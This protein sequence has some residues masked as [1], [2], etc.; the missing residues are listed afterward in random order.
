MIKEAIQRIVDLT[1][2]TMKGEVVID[3]H[4]YTDRDL[5]RIDPP[6]IDRPK[7]IK[8]NSLDSLILML[9]AE[10]SKDGIETP[11]FVRVNGAKSVEVYTTYNNDFTRNYLY[12]V[13][14]DTPD[15]RFGWQDYEEAMIA[16]RSQFKQDDGILYILD[17]LKRVTD[18]ESVSTSDNGLTQTVEVKKGVSLKA[19]ENVR[20]H[21]KLRPYRTFLEIEQP[22]SEFLLRLNENGQVG[23]FEADG[24]M[25]KLE[26]R[27]TVRDYLTQ[28]LGGMNSAGKVIVTI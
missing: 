10:V 4:T 1:H 27:R 16:L 12:E 21:V 9:S 20:P 28:G 2:E 14:A 15:F 17:L 23:L 26:A 22:A 11:V 6:A 5:S 3:G 19:K 13:V 7:S 8:L 25:W 18:E 24:G